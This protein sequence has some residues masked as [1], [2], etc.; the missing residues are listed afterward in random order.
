MCLLYLSVFISFV[1]FSYELEYTNNETNSPGQWFEQLNEELKELNHAAAEY[2]WESSTLPTQTSTVEK[3]IQLTVQKSHWT[4]AICS[5]GTQYGDLNASF[6]RALYLL[7]QSPRNSDEEIREITRLLG[8][9]QGIYTGTQV[10]LEDDRSSQDSRRSLESVTYL[11]YN[12]SGDPVSNG[13]T[14][15]YGEPDLEKIMANEIITEPNQP[16]SCSLDEER[17]LRWVWNS[18]RLAVGPPMKHSFKQLIDLMN[19]GARR[20]GFQDIGAAWRAELEIPN[21]RALVHQ[22]WL[23]VKPLYHKLHAVLR[24][25]LKNCYA[26]LASFHRDGLIPAHLVGDMWSQNWE[27]HV[28]SILP[29]EVNIERNFRAANWTSEHLA[30]RAE[31]FYSSMGLPMMSK[32]FWERS[33]FGRVGNVTKCHGS[34]GNMFDEDDYR[35]ITCAGN[36]MSDFYVIVHEMGHIIYYMLAS[37]Q[38]TVFQDGTNSAFHESVGDTIHLAALNPLHLVRLGLLDSK[39]LQPEAADGLNSFDYALLLKTALIKIPAIPFSYVMDRYRWDLFDETIDFDTEAN[40]Y[41]WQ[42]LEQEQGIRSPSEIDR[43]NLFDVASKYHFSDNTPYVRYFLANFLSFQILE[44]LC[45][46]SIF[47]TLE[48]PNELPM[49]LHRCDLYGSKRAG[50]LLKKALALGGSQHWS[51][52]LKILT[53]S[54]NISS[55]AMLNYFE[56]IV[57]LLDRMI[58][59][60]KIPVGW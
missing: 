51:V 15:L 5:R 12:D 3:I 58:H 1:L 31:D 21:L 52:V 39:Y 29:H 50:R 19:D 46:K 28:A 38:P 10:C 56:P 42:L 18:W 43:T 22:L 53:G 26:E 41:F 20:A 45:K 2:A 8:F 54:E 44:G 6:S 48:N 60:A 7:C 27:K 13:V 30:K 49:P 4:K 40:S 59:D 17:V 32:N 11:K 47:G 34:A 14:C 36:T 16:K 35:M 57:A 25:F 24:Y 33:V 55:A 37:T 23:D 9:M